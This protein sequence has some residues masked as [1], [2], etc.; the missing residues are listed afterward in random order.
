MTDTK[1]AVKKE[2]VPQSTSG[3]GH[4]RH[5]SLLRGGWERGGGDHGQINA[6]CSKNVTRRATILKARF[7]GDIKYLR[8]AYF[9]C[10]GNYRANIYDVLMKL[11]SRYVTREYA[12]SVDIRHV[13]MKM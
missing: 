12:H 9:N 4:E 3:G 1:P 6:R 8:G 11:I 2:S 13:V 10:A 7:E 5:Q